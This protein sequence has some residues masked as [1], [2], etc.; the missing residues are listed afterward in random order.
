MKKEFD[1]NNKYVFLHSTVNIKQLD[2]I[3][4]IIT[5]NHFILFP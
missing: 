1:W 5:S 2:I 4:S 3:F